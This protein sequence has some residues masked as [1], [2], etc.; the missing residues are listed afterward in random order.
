MLLVCFWKLWHLSA[1]AVMQSDRSFCALFALW[2]AY[3]GNFSSTLNTG[4]DNLQSQF[5]LSVVTSFWWCINITN[6]DACLSPQDIF[7]TIKH[8]HSHCGWKP[9]LCWPPTIDFRHEDITEI[10]KPVN[11]CLDQ[12]IL[13]GSF[14]HV[15]SPYTRNNCSCIR[16]LQF[17]LS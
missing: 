7:Y 17:I 8:A 4:T 15:P 12:H 1:C 3:P 9:Y 2:M 5:T 16:R 11:L 10:T 6:G 14:I 13:F